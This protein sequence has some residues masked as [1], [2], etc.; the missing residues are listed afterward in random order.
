MDHH[1]QNECHD[2]IETSDGDHK[3]M[4]TM[5]TKGINGV[6]SFSP[7]VVYNSTTLVFETT[8]TFTNAHSR[9]HTDS[10]TLVKQL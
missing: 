5:F 3:L 10:P 4:F 7:R 6:K 2:V 8:E 1:L 9:E